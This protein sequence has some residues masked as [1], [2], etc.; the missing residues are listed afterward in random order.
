V[1]KNSRIALMSSM[2]ASKNLEFMKVIFEKVLFNSGK[3]PS[4]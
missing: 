1:A 4:E 3:K 2:I